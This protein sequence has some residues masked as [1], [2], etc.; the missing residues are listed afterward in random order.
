MSKP[1][2]QLTSDYTALLDML[3]DDADQESVINTLQCVEGAIEVKAQ[4]IATI[5]RGLDDDASAINAEIKRLQLRKKGA[6]S[7]RDW[8][9]QYVGQ[10]ME[11]AGMD[12]IKTAT[13]TIALQNNPPSVEIYNP[14][15]I[16]AQYVTIK[17]E[18][19]PDKKRIE[20]AIKAGGVV[21]GAELKQGRS[22][23]IR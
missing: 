21:P 12:K 11:L 17:T 2:Y 18:Y 22:I 16:P 7:R 6:E 4:S 14:D 13:H 1:L 3:D 19:V 20:E 9:K 5:I 23:R 8:L 15:V 10:Q